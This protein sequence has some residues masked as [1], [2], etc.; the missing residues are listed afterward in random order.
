MKIQ[1]KYENERDKKKLIDS[2]A[3]EFEIVNISKL[4]K[5]GRYYRIYVDINVK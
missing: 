3:R 1:I 5:S 2:L 4:Y